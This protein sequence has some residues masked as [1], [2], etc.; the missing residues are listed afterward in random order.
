M[1][2]LR[3]LFGKKQINSVQQSE[4]I[5]A[6]STPSPKYL[7]IIFDEP[8]P[9]YNMDY[10]VGQLLRYLEQKNGVNLRTAKRKVEVRNIPNKEDF[11]DIM[12]ELTLFALAD[13][14][15]GQK[16]RNATEGETQNAEIPPDFGNW[17]IRRQWVED[18][19]PVSL[20][21]QVAWLTPPK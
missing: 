8:G 9:H 19:F 12:K 17:D 7:C 11:D 14:T 13:I 6:S 3:N 2:F 20:I 15:I 1:S 18:K 5:L 10:V 16:I 4:S 21:S